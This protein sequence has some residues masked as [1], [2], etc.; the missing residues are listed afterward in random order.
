MNNKTPYSFMLTKAIK[1]LK[2]TI[3]LQRI[4]SRLDKLAVPTL[5][6]GVELSVIGRLDW[7][8]EHYQIN[9][10]DLTPYERLQRLN[11]DIATL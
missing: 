2:S 7:L 4:S 6:N 11:S 8:I 10:D 1:H 5:N 3:E 9:A